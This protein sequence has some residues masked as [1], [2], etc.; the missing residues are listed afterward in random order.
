MEEEWDYKEMKAWLLE[1]GS[2]GR[3]IGFQQFNSNGV[4][5][6][7]CERLLDKQN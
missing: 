7:G 6:I 3:R 4:Q 2:G 1:S 5:N